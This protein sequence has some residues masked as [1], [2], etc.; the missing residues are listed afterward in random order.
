MSSF[1]WRLK[2]LCFVDRQPAIQ[3]VSVMPVMLV[4]EIV[5]VK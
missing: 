4:G 5:P 1:V 3:V 2:S